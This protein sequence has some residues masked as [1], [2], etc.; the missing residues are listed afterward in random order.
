ML[1]WNGRARHHKGLPGISNALALD[2]SFLQ[3]LT[4]ER[5]RRFCEKHGIWCDGQISLLSMFL[6]V[7]A[8]A[9][10]DWG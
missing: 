6:I 2:N 5:G 3:W 10:D 7:K 8:D 9:K 4:G 1:H